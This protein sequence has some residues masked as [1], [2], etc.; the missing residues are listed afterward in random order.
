MKLLLFQKS[1]LLILFAISLTY[2]LSFRVI[3]LLPNVVTNVQLSHYDLEGQGR[4]PTIFTLVFDNLGDEQFHRNLQ[5]IYTIKIETASQGSQVAYKGRTAQ[6]TLAPNSHT[7][8]LS[9][10]FMKDNNSRTPI[11]I[12]YTLEEF[13]N[14]DLEKQVFDAGTIPTGK[15]IFEFE[16]IGSVD[17]ENIE[18]VEV[19]IFNPNQVNLIS[20]GIISEVSEMYDIPQYNDGVMLF[21]WTSDLTASMYDGCISCDSKDVFEFQLFQRRV[22]QSES[23]A[24]TSHPILVKRT[25]VPF[26]QLVTVGKLERGATYYWKV[27]GLLQGILDGKIE[28]EPFV[29]RFSDILDPDV[30]EIKRLIRS[31]LSL[32]GNESYMEHVEDFDKSIQLWRSGEPIKLDEL[33]E[34]EQNLID[35]KKS[36]QSITVN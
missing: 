12:A 22:G 25:R 16:L 18:T 30:E 23:D 2:S 4:G 36:V 24:L 1:F 29:F 15:L 26:V 9:N 34:L 10:D 6:F 5:L 33:R 7:E 21:N 17:G 19:D 14:T 35:G 11:H 13:D 8:V 32:S 3:P 20:P 27:Y 31:I 28:S